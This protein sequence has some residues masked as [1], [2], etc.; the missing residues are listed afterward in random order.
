MTKL[1]DL[2]PALDADADNLLVRKEQEITDEFLANLRDQRLE[3][4]NARM[5][6]NVRIATIPVIVIEKWLREGFDVNKASAREVI[7]KLKADGLEGFLAT[8]KS[9]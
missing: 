5:G 2:T 9:F 6:E 4:A 1:L 3:S 8:T 7:R